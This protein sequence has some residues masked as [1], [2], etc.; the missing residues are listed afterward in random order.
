MNRSSPTSSITGVSLW[1]VFACCA[2][3][4]QSTA[5]DVRTTQLAASASYYQRDLGNCVRGNWRPEAT[6]NGL[7]GGGLISCPEYDGWA[8]GGTGGEGQDQYILWTFQAGA[9][10]TDGIQLLQSYSVYQYPLYLTDFELSYTTSPSPSLQSQFRPLPLTSL[11]GVSGYLNGNNVRAF[12]GPWTAAGQDY[13]VDWIP[14][15]ATGIRLHVY[16]LGGAYGGG[17]AL[18]EVSFRSVPGSGGSYEVFGSGCGARVP[19]LAA[20]SGQLPRAGQQFTVSIGNL[21]VA[22][23]PPPT[24]LIFGYSQLNLN[25]TTFGAPGC[26]LVPNP[27][28]LLNCAVLPFGLLGTCTFQVPAL[29]GLTFYNQAL[30]LDPSATA[31]GIALSPPARGVIG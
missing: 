18:T 7:V 10:T 23:P 16:P 14:T 25:L 28:A 13:R 27:D 31:L 1:A 3:P 22:A 6:V 15:M 20:A 26:V 19:T 21:P 12:P 17:F 30:V 24:F 5:Y 2:V 29:R 4:A 9:R 11:G 8:V